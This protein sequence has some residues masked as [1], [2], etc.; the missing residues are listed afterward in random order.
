MK[1]NID[2]INCKGI[3]RLLN[4][5]RLVLFSETCHIQMKRKR[6][7]QRMADILS[8]RLISLEFPFQI[9]DLK[10]AALKKSKT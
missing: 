1:P 10:D 5:G 6:G 3:L 2:T 9:E 8:R 4:A 7:K